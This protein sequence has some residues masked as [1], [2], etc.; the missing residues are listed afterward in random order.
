MANARCAALYGALSRIQSL[1][2]ELI[3]LSRPAGPE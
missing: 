3:E 1:G 2:L